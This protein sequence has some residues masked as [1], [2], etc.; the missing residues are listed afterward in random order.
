MRRSDPRIT[1]ARLH[2]YFR[3]VNRLF[4]SADKSGALWV[5]DS[6]LLVRVP[7]EKH[8]VAL[9][10]AE[11]NLP[12]EPMVCDV[13]RTVRRRA[14]TPPPDIT[15]LLPPKGWDVKVTPLLVD[16]VEVFTFSEKGQPA[17][18]MER[19]DG[20]RV[21]LSERKRRLVVDL[22]SPDGEWAMQ[23]G[24]DLRSPVAYRVDGATAGL[25]MPI[26]NLL[27]QVQEA[28]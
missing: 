7:D 23:T 1:T 8:P 10:L 15:K 13:G 26:T 5:T 6:Y 16:G 24:R 4:I 19:V 18:L 22:T 3:S 25:L 21:T 9:L 20:K 12:L 2:S 14:D 11:F 17:V 28:A 27:T